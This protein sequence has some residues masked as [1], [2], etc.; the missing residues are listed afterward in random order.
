MIL[1]FALFYFILF[2]WEQLR[3]T[4]GSTWRGSVGPGRGPRLTEPPRALGTATTL[5]LLAQSI[6]SIHIRL[7]FST[8]RLRTEQRSGV[9][10]P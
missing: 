10:I 2:Y 7:D 4:L 5:L 3:L 9:G 6:S 8:S 1:Y